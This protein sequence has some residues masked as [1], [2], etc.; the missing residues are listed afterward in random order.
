MKTLQSYSSEAEAQ[1]VRGMLA[2]NGIA[3]TVGRY[4]RYRA[5]A[6]G[7]WLLRVPPG[8]YARA[9][10]ILEKTSSGPDMDEYVDPDDLSYRRCP[11]C[12]SVNVTA[13]EEPFLKALAG[14]FRLISRNWHCGKCGHT[15]V[16]R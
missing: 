16:A 10:A 6:A 9:Q 7:G 5:M 4:S 8:D 12:T 14:A 13:A 3:A 11:K 2:G 15:W 1:L